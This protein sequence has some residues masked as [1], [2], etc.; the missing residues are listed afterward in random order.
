MEIGLH[1]AVVAGY[2]RIGVAACQVDVD[3]PD[4]IDFTLADLRGKVVL[5]HSGSQRPPPGRTGVAGPASIRGTAR[6]TQ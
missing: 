4:G 6:D 1:E 5:A 2:G 3:V